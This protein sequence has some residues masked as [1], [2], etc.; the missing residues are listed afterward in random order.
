ML[1]KLS[2]LIDYPIIVAN[3]SLISLQII[4]KI[5]TDL[6]D[7]IRFSLTNRILNEQKR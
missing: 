1:N 5:G 4:P 3:D 7:I 2:A 6:L